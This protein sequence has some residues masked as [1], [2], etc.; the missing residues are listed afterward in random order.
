QLSIEGPPVCGPGLA[1]IDIGGKVR[2]LVEDARSFQSAQ[3]RYHQ[4][5]TGAEGAVEPVTIAKPAGEAVEPL[6]DAVLKG[7]QALLVPGLAAFEDHRHGALENRW[8]DG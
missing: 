7:P 1:A 6:A 3:H 5:I 2:I 4:Q 8:L